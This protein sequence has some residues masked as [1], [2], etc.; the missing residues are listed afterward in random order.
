MNHHDPIQQLK[1]LRQTLSQD[2]KPLGFFIS[3]GCPLAIK[4]P[5]E[6]WPLI[7]DVA[8][9]TKYVTDELKSKDNNVKNDYDL[10]LGEVVKA[11]KNSHNIEDILSFVRGLKQVASGATDIR[12][13]SE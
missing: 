10:L 2:K 5:K 11:G 13:L 9:L 3:A 1:Y 12:G 7:P 6:R 4:L 8:G